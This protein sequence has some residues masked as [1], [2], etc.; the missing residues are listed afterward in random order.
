MSEIVSKRIL[1]LG[2][3]LIGGSIARGLKQA[4]KEIFVSACDIEE[5]Q[6]N[7]ALADRV[8]DKSGSLKELAPSSD[9]LIIAL[10]SLTTVELIPEIAQA[11]GKN[12]GNELNR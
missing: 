7:Q 11:V 3:G 5:Q 10:P 6:L 1:I 4:N 2:L 12:C 9:I 8:I